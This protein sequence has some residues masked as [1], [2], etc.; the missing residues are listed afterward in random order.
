MLLAAASLGLGHRVALPADE[1]RGL[2]EAGPEV[3]RLGHQPIGSYAFLAEEVRIPNFA[4]GEKR[5]G[6]RSDGDHFLRR[7][8]FAAEFVGDRASGQQDGPR[9]LLGWWEKVKGFREVP[10]ANAAEAIR[11]SGS[12]ASILDDDVRPKD[13]AVIIRPDSGLLHANVSPLRVKLLARRVSVRLDSPM[14]LAWFR[15]SI[16]T[17]VLCRIASTLSVVALACLAPWHTKRYVKTIIMNV[18]RALV[19]VAAWSQFQPRLGSCFLSPLDSPSSRF[20]WR[21]SGSPIGTGDG[22][23]DWLGAVPRSPSRLLSGRCSCCWLS[24]AN[25]HS[26]ADDISRTSVASSSKALV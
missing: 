16:A 24:A 1:H 20:G 10:D 14:A 23:D 18:A 11:C 22:Y 6:I 17:A 25:E 5:Q 13:S 19:I 15:A 4:V 26:G 3:L 9:A 21:S 2:F 8:E 7:E 12:D